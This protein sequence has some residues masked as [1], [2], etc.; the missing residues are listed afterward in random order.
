MKR[1]MSRKFIA[2]MATLAAATWCL[3]EGLIA[4]ADWKAVVLGTVAAYVTSNVAQK[5]L[6]KEPAA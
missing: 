1:Y 2:A 6:V 3:A 5:A 4:A